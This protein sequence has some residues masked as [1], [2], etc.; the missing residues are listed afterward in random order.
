MYIS[1][2]ELIDAIKA[3]HS[4]RKYL[5]KPIEAAKVATLRA[6]VE[7]INADTGFNIQLV[8]D[9]PKALPH[10][11]SGLWPCSIDQSGIVSSPRVL[12]RS[13]IAGG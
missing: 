11:N 10:K 4:V 3:R 5:D 7:R 8:L 6:T 9:E 2:M 12:Q 13:I 1:D